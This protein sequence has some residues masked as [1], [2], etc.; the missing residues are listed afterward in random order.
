MFKLFGD[1]I[2]SPVGGDNQPGQPAV[3]RCPYR[4]R[5]AKRCDDLKC[6]RCFVICQEW[7]LIFLSTLLMSIVMV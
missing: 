1:I 2:L 5:E 4:P 7:L 6:I 3:G